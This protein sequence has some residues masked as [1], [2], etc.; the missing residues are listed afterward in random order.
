[1]NVG[2]LKYIASLV[3]GQLASA[4]YTGLTPSWIVQNTNT[5]NVAANVGQLKQVFD[6][7]LSVAPAAVTDV[8]ATGS[9]PGEIDLSWTLPTINNA[10]SIVIEEST[11]GGTTWTTIDT[12]TNPALVSYAITGLNQGSSFRFRIITTNF[13][14]SA[15][16]GESPIIVAPVT[17]RYAVI[18]LGTYFAPVGINNNGMVA[19]N[20][21][22]AAVWSQGTATNLASGPLGTGY[23]STIND[24]GVIAGQ[25]NFNYV[26]G[27]TTNAELHACSWASSNSAPVDLDALHPEALGDTNYFS[28][29][30]AL[31]TNGVVYGASWVDDSPVASIYSATAAPVSAAPSINPSW[32]LGPQSYPLSAAGTNYSGFYYPESF[33][34]TNAAIVNGQGIVPDGGYKN[35][36]YWAINTRGEAVG[37]EQDLSD[38]NYCLVLYQNGTNASLPGTGSTAYSSGLAPGFGGSHPQPIYGINTQTTT[39]GTNTVSAPQI[40]G[41]DSTGANVLLW[42]RTYYDGT[43]N[44]NTTNGGYVAKNLNL[45]IPGATGTNTPPWTI[46]SVSGINNYGAIVG[47]ATYSGTNFATGT[48]GVMLVPVQI[49]LLN[50]SNPDFDGTIVTVMPSDFPTP[51]VPATPY[52]NSAADAGTNLGVATPMGAGRNNN[53]PDNAYSFVLMAAA[54]APPGFQYQWERFIQRRSWY[55]KKTTSGTNSFWDVSWRSSR[56]FSDNDTNDLKNTGDF[57]DSTPSSVKHEFYS[58]DS[59]ALGYGLAG[60][61]SMNTNDCIHEEKNFIYKVQIS[62]DGINWTDA[63]TMPVAQSE[64]ITYIATQGSAATDWAG[65]PNFTGGNTMTQ[66]ASNSLQIT[67]A[68]VQSIVGTSLPITIETNA[69]THLDGP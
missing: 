43:I 42:D 37:V 23:A 51:G 34:S 69:N 36:Y 67:T 39:V 46:T 9:N 26:N 40:V 48:H 2:Q 32:G 6:F 47:T 28:Y 50:G 55:I 56:G 29:A 8:V 58:H 24:A 27:L 15:S 31:D 16:P 25:A 57:D 66:G 62:P 3:Y 18:D 10:T 60:D 7:D 61:S 11:D 59:S 44:T 38:G 63:A 64:T 14:G 68:K 19:G 13:V 4:G 22:S 20:N 52:D 45:L 54:K 17:P 12:L 33:V 30:T 1:M 41:S 5:D 35:L 53:A 65:V 49:T 21:G